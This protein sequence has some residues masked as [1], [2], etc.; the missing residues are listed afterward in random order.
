MQTVGAGGRG[1]A[2]NECGGCSEADETVL[3]TF[4]MV[5]VTVMVTQLCDELKT[6]ELYTLKE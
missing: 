4:Q 6:T 2:V 1:V 5:M 3:E